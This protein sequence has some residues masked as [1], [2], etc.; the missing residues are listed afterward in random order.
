MAVGAELRFVMV[1]S[2]RLRR[3]S[4]F[5]RSHARCLFWPRSLSVCPS[6]PGWKRLLIR[7]FSGVSWPRKGELKVV[8]DV[9]YV[10]SPLIGI[11][12]GSK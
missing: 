4:F 7:I 8:W 6:S 1:G 10:L 11:G 3:P 2:R 5:S 12:A 9:L